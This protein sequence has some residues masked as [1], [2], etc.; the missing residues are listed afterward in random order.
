MIIDHR[1]RHVDPQI[2]HVPDWVDDA[3]L[4]TA[5]RDL[6]DEFTTPRLGH[7]DR[8]YWPVDEISGEVWP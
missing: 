4:E 1:D 5:I 2:P 6:L 3:L 7:A 8:L